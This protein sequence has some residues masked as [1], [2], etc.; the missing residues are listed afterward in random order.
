MDILGDRQYFANHNTTAL[1]FS[2]YCAC[3][4][5]EFEHIQCVVHVKGGNMKTLNMVMKKINMEILKAF[6]YFL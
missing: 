6:L 2:I 1:V 3:W 4:Q 5:V